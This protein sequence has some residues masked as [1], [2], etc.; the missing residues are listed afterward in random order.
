MIDKLV[1]RTVKNKDK[2]FLIKGNNEIKKIEKQSIDDNDDLI[3]LLSALKKKNIKILDKN[4]QTI[5]FIA[6]DLN[7][8]LMF[9]NEPVF[10]IL[11]QYIIKKERQKG[12]ASLLIKEV[13]KIANEKKY[14]KVYADVYNI[15]SISLIYSKKQKFKPVYTVYEKKI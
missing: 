10:W 3:R 15:N 13:L 12:Y 2:D 4:N 6:Y 1:I 8:K 11:E 7:Y 5:G 14:N 9:Y